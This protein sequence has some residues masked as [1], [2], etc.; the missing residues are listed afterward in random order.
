MA[1]P[2][3][4]GNNSAVACHANCYV[5]CCLCFITTWEALVPSQDPVVLDMIQKMVFV[6]TVFMV[7]LVYNIASQ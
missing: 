2:I 5:V 6:S 7:L 4:L 1:I 3:V